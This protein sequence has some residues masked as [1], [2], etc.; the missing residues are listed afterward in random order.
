MCG[1]TLHLLSLASLCCEGRSPFLSRQALDPLEHRQSQ[2]LLHADA[3]A[4]GRSMLVHP[5]P[6]GKGCLGRGLGEVGILTAYF[7]QT[8]QQPSPELG[9]SGAIPIPQ[10]YCTATVLSEITVKHLPII[11]CSTQPKRTLN[12]KLVIAGLAALLLSRKN[13]FYQKRLK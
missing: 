4:T 10:V 8:T 13:A 1:S 2:R 12:V 9:G 5:P 11:A 6:K 7:P 3:C